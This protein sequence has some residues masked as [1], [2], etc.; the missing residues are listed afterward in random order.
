MLSGG[1]SGG[2]LPDSGNEPVWQVLLT[3]LEV[4]LQAAGKWLSGFLEPSVFVV[5]LGI[6]VTALFTNIRL[7][8]QGNSAAKTQESDYAPLQVLRI[9]ASKLGK[10]ITVANFEVPQYELAALVSNPGNRP[11][12]LKKLRLIPTVSPTS[13]AITAFWSTPKVNERSFWLQQFRHLKQRL[14]R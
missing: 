6:L 2:S 7:R 13:Q 12:H 3:H 4:G 5:L 1:L 8:K 10:T 9:D 11:V 14:E